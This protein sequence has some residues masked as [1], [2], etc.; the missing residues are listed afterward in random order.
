M[1]YFYKNWI[2]GH[3]VLYAGLGILDIAIGILVYLN[4]NFV[5]T[6][7]SL[8]FSLSFLY[9]VVGIR[10]LGKSLY[11]NDV[12]DWR[13]YADIIAA[14]LLFLI[15]YGIVF[16]AFRFLGGIIAVKGFMSAFLITTKQ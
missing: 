16:D 2:E 12:F 1:A 10:S 11:R 8:I 13:G 5:L 15:Y 14:V 4:S 7:N 3:H 6:S 9:F